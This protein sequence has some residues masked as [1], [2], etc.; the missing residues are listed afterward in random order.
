MDIVSASVFILIGIGVAVLFNWLVHDTVNDIL[1]ERGVGVRP[2]K[3][4]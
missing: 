3:R 4:P 1:D 2:K